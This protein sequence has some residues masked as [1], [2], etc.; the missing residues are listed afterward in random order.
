M[1]RFKIGATLLIAGLVAAAGGCIYYQ[2]KSRYPHGPS[3]C[4]IL[5]MSSSLESYASANNGRYPSGGVTPEASLGLLNGDYGVG[6]EILRG[7]TVPESK[8]R[9]ALERGHPL[10]PGTC[11]W[12][13][14]EGL[15]SADDPRIALLWCKEALDHNGRR[16]PDGRRQVVYVGGRTQQVSGDRWPHFL[17]EQAKLI[18]NRSERAKQG[19]PLVSAVV[20]LPDGT[21]VERINQSYRLTKVSKG[22]KSSGS[23]HSS[24]TSFNA[25]QLVWFHPPIENGTVTRTLSL[26]DMQSDPVTVTFTDGKPDTNAV[27]FKLRTTKP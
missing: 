4:C 21:Q 11:G 23:G 14:V 17:A 10:S 20:E 8:T 3:H 19:L 27:M 15:T 9:R 1:S 12:H 18:G 24:G 13:Y 5:A 2:W 16:W 22:P 26:G 6:F 25:S 7:M